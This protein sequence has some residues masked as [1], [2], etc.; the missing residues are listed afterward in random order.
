MRV[1]LSRCLV[2]DFF[3]LIELIECDCFIKYRV[4]C[5]KVKKLYVR[6]A[7]KHFTSLIRDGD[8]VKKVHDKG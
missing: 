2:I 7:L 4:A 1:N 6:R 5:K 8:V 3:L